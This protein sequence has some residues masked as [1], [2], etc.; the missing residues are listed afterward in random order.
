MALVPRFRFEMEQAGIVFEVCSLVELH[1]LAV[2]LF[3]LAQLKKLVEGFDAAVLADAQEDDP[4]NRLLYSEIKL[5]FVFHLGVAQCDVA[6]QQDAPVLD[7]MQEGIIHLDSASL[8]GVIL[9]V[10]IEGSLTDGI[11]RDD[12]GDL[13]PLIDVFVVTKIHNTPGCRAVC[14]VGLAAAVIDGEFLEI[15]QDGNW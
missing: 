8:G 1:K 15:G 12:T 7:L 11:R 13:I 10:F 5:A 3:P 9:G 14:P 6:C 4:V 2:N